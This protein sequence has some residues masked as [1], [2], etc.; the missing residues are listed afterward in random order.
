V[1]KQNNLGPAPYFR[2]PLSIALVAVA[3]LALSGCS[4]LKK[5][6]KR[7][8]DEFSVVTSA[9]LVIPPDYGLR[10]PEPSVVRARELAKEEE[11]EAALFGDNPLS[12]TH[13]ASPGELALLR[14]MGALSVDDDIRDQILRENTKLGKVVEKNALEKMI[15]WRAENK[16]EWS[17]MLGRGQEREGKYIPSDGST[18]SRPDR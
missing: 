18:S 13:E 8:P 17:D 14:Q 12:I 1:I 7:S 5:V 10:P 6:N 16:S 9:P 3:L 2:P 4:S 15:W 11:T